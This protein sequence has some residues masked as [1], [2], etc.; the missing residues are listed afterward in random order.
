MKKTLFVDTIPLI[1]FSLAASAGINETTPKRGYKSVASQIKA[2]QKLIRSLPKSP[3]KRKAVVF[4][5]AKRV[6]LALHDDMN[7]KLTQS[8]LNAISDDDKEAI[9]NFYRRP[10]IVWTA[11]GLKDEITVCGE[12]MERSKS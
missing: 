4:G 8:H 11:P 5:F 7:Q 10:D 6:G 9:R 3:S 1:S 2:E 12:R